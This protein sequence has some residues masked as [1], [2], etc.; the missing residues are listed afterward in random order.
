MAKELNE[1]L[2]LLLLALADDKL[3]IGHRNSDWTGLAPILE[4][5][6]AF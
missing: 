2:T 6:I 5:D 3:L 1:P 4:E